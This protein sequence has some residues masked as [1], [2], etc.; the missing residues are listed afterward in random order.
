MNWGAIFSGRG[1]KRSAGT[2]A[3]NVSAVVLF[4]FNRFGRKKFWLQ[5]CKATSAKQIFE[6]IQEGGKLPIG[7]VDT[8]N[9]C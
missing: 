2:A 9:K 3:F 1:K 5:S 4:I 7:G 6:E 8:S